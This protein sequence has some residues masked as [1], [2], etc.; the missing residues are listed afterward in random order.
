MAYTKEIH[1]LIE[2]IEHLKTAML[3]QHG[4]T[5]SNLLE[6]FELGYEYG[7]LF[8]DLTAEGDEKML[9]HLKNEYQVFA[10]WVEESLGMQETEE[11]EDEGE[12]D[13]D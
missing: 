5:G 9:A 4:I 11:D 10:D 8:D 1:D 3:E 13:E 6:V 2:H 12:D 7:S